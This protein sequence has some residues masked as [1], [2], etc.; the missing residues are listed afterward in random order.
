[1]QTS[2]FAEQKNKESPLQSLVMTTIVAKTQ[3]ALS[4]EEIKDVAE[5]DVYRNGTH[6]TTVVDNYYIDRDFSLDEIYT[7]TIKSKRS[8]VK[9]EERFNVFKSIVSTVFGLLNPV[10][11][12]E[13]AA[14]E[15]F[16]VTKAI[17]KPM[18]LLTP[19]QDR[20]RLPNVDR[21]GFRYMTFLQDDW[22]LNPNMLSEI[23]ILKGM[24]GDLIQMGTVIVPEWTL[25][26][27]MILNVLL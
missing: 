18:E 24:T 12:K 20:V 1:M 25:N 17:A 8:L 22:V 7:Y 23:V 5:Y 6:M 11:S 19:V 9:S 15:Q 16:S 26:W 27:H 13:E 3:I 4:W 2:A 10:S 14:I 21:W